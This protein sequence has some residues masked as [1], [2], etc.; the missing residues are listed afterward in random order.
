MKAT[1]ETI[2]LVTE[3]TIGALIEIVKV[4]LTLVK[5]TIAVV[6]AVLHGDWAGAL[7]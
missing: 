1:W 5:D 3:S 2:K 4:G 7:E 6:M